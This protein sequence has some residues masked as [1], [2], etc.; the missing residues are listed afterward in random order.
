MKI[1]KKKKKNTHPPNQ[2]VPFLLA[3]LEPKRQKGNA[4]DFNV[5]CFDGGK[6]VDFVDRFGPQT[7]WTCDDGKSK[8]KKEPVSSLSK[9]INREKKK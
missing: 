4:A 9:R 7:F 5:F 2:P 6:R 8:I 1:Y 3:E